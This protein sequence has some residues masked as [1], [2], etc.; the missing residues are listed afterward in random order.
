M[1][2][3]LLYHTSVHQGTFEVQMAETEVDNL[4]PIK[5]INRGALARS[6]FS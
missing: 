4:E 2:Q 1:L 3:T 6:V 5:I